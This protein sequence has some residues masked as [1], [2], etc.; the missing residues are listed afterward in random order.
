MR[1]ILTKLRDLLEELKV[2]YLVAGSCASS[3]YGEPRSTNDVDI[4]IDPSR[5]QLDLLVARLKSFC[6]VQADFARQMFDSRSMFTALD[7]ET[8]RKVDFIFPKNRPYSRSEFEHGRP[9]MIQGVLMQTISP[10]DTIL[11]K[12]EWS[13]MG[14]SER[15][16]RDAACVAA[17]KWGN[18]DQEYLRKWAEQLG[19]TEYLD[20]L[21][22][23]AQR[24]LRGEEGKSKS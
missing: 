24:I 15:Q 13:K 2:P 21:L 6:L 12:L 11:S 14:E 9:A 20:R 23:H 18:L 5:E 1:E 8:N 16:F 3:S 19:L 17:V 22:D 4:L 10:E 7:I